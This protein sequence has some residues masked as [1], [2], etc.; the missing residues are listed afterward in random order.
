MVAGGATEAF[1]LADAVVV[2][3]VVAS[4]GQHRAFASLLASWSGMPR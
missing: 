4:V 1:A 2:V 3:S